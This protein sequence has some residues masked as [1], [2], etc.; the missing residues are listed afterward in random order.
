MRFLFRAAFWLLV[1]SA[2]I[3]ARGGVPTAGPS[4]EGTVTH[5]LA[6]AGDAVSSWCADKPARCLDLAGAGVGAL[7]LAG[8]AAADAAPAL[9]A[10]AVPLPAARPPGLGR[11]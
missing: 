5:G 6:A 4:L 7:R 1:M 9:A 3:P 10:R 2:V 8:A 11:G